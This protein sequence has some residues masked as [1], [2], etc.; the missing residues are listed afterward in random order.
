MPPLNIFASFEFDKDN[1]LKNNFFPFHRKDGFY[2]RQTEGPSPGRGPARRVRGGDAI[3]PD[4]R[5]L[6]LS[7]E[8]QA[9]DG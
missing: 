3:I 4:S 5:G 1:E 7:L 8:R 9:V 6:L 2:M